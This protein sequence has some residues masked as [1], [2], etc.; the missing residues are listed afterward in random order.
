[1]NLRYNDQDIFESINTR[2]CLVESANCI[3]LPKNL[4]TETLLYSLISEEEFWFGLLLVPVN[5]T[6]IVPILMHKISQCGSGVN[7]S[8]SKISTRNQYSKWLN[9][10]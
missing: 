9:K 8:M 1:M 5:C 3:P 10:G 2:R 6:T 4:G 7:R